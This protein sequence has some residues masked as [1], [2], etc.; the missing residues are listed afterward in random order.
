MLIANNLEPF[1]EKLS[2]N[3]WVVLPIDIHLSQ[4]LK[5][6]AIQKAFKFYEAKTSQNIQTN[7]QIRSDRILWLD[8]TQNDLSAAEQNIL[9]YLTEIQELLRDYFRV[10]LSQIECHYSHYQRGQFYTT[11]QDTT[12]LNNKRLFSFVIYLNE[13]WTTL[14][15]GAL[16]GYNQDDSELFRLLPISGQMIVFKSDLLHEVQI[17]NRDRYSLT[18]WFRI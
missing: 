3:S 16:V 2:Q 5:E 10:G 11:H 15:G 14:D 18:G 1:F 7:T 8:T 6:A 9:T 12:L 13:E 17:T 4:Q